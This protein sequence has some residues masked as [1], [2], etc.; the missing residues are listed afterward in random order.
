VGAPLLVFVILFLLF[1]LFASLTAPRAGGPL[2]P[3]L[4]REGMLVGT[5]WVFLAL[6]A[7]TIL[8]T[9]WPV[10]SRLWSAKTVGLSPVFYNTVCLPLFAVIALLLAMCPWVGWRGRIAGKGR[11]LFVSGIALGCGVLLYAVGQKRMLPVAGSA[12]AVAILVSVCLQVTGAAGLA[13]GGRSLAAH[14]AHAGFAVIVLGVAF[15][16][17]YKVQENVVLLP[18]RSVVFGEYALT[19]ETVRG[20]DARDHDRNFAG[21]AE[22]PG[23]ASPPPAYIYSEAVL[24]VTRDGKAAG[25]LRPR[26]RRYAK[27]PAD[28]FSEVDTLFSWGNEL[29]C[30][31]L[32]L[33]GNGAATLQISLNPMVNWIWAGGALLCLAPLAGMFRSGSGAPVSRAPHFPHPREDAP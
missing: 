31:L 14:L 29:Y 10:V 21:G 28:T 20:G 18:G 13:R 23:G 27:Y 32:G 16:G 6:A 4:S 30:S 11:A 22:R 8:G 3:L 15:S 25:E 26:L 17:P 2:D 1:T 24:G 12:A 7:I 9:L 19:L 5:C 33:D